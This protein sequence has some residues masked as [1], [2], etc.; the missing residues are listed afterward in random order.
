MPSYQKAKMNRRQLVAAA[1]GSLTAPAFLRGAP[2]NAIALTVS[3]RRLSEVPLERK[4][5]GQFGEAGFGRQVEGM[6]AEMLY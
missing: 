6:W 5:F 1:T 2:E 4:I 3:G